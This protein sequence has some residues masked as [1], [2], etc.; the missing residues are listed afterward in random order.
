MSLLWWSRRNK[1]LLTKLKRPSP[2]KTEPTQFLSQSSQKVNLYE[3][4]KGI[5][6]S[7]SFS[8]T[9]NASMTVEAAVVLPLFL[10]FFLNLSSA[11]EMIRLHGNVELALWNVGNRLSVYGSVLQGE[12][13]IQEAAGDEKVKDQSLWKQLAGIGFS[14][15]MIKHFMVDFLGE[16]YLNTSPIVGGADGLQF[17]ESKLFTDDDHFEIVVAYGVKPPFQLN[18]VYPM[19]MVNHYYGHVW[20][21]YEIPREQEQ[22]RDL[23]YVTEHGSVYHENP[24]CTHLSLT[25]REVTY[26][27]AYTEKNESGEKYQLCEICKKGKHSK[28][29]LGRTDSVW[30]TTDGNRIHLDRGC[31]GLKRTVYAIER[32]RVGKYRPCSRCGETIMINGVN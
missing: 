12:T 8:R 28:D 15:T 3:A 30:I 23:V 7:A 31:S 16:E 26:E 25:I 1:Q 27:Q 21:G 14:Y 5:T 10:L 24:A 20:N 22:A 17:L 11:M 13:K 6:M 32:S 9:K 29:P 19:G 18:G 2:K 4:I